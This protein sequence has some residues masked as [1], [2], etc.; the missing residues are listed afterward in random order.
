MIAIGHRHFRQCDRRSHSLTKSPP[1]VTRRTIFFGPLASLPV[2]LLHLSESWWDSP[3]AMLSGDKR[4]GSWKL[5]IRSRSVC[6][7][8]LICYIL[9]PR[10]GAEWFI[11]EF[12][13]SQRGHTR[14]S[15]ANCEPSLIIGSSSLQSRTNVN[16]RC[17]SRDRCAVFMEFSPRECSSES[18]VKSR[19]AGLV[20][21]ENTVIETFRVGLQIPSASNICRENQE[22]FYDTHLRG[23]VS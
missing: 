1:T 21:N 2:F 7:A 19:R 12:P 17:R 8:D 10:L 11:V 13:L 15:R 4:R 3:F 23:K 18:L 20:A 6:Q 14:D 5:W 9:I 16:F 22:K